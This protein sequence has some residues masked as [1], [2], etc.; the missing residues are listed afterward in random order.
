MC[1][2]PRQPL[3]PALL[4]R[5]SADTRACV[6]ACP[7]AADPDMCREQCLKADTTP[8]DP[9][10]GVDC[11]GC[12]YVQLFACVDRANCHTGVADVFCCIEANCPAG[13]PEGCGEQHCS[14]QIRTAL[15]CGYYAD[16]SCLDFLGSSISGCFA[17]GDADA[18]AE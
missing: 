8:R 5:C 9:T 12:V 14:S 4:P 16:M 7:Q 17:A 13:S 1:A 6:A 15:T 18:G 2:R 11:S 10:T 3:P